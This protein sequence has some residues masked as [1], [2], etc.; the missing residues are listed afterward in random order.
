MTLTISLVGPRYKCGRMMR[1]MIGDKDYGLITGV[2]LTRISLLTWHLQFD[3][4][5]KR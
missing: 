5:V 2:K 3:V 4:E 1:S